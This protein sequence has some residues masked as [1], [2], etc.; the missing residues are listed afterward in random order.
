MTAPNSEQNQKQQGDNN[1]KPGQ[2]NQTPGQQPQPGHDD[3]KQADQKKQQQAS[4]QKDS[5]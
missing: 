3:A 2:Q 4:A 5:I 1:Q